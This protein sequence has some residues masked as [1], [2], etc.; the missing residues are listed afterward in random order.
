MNSGDKSDGPPQG[1]E[2]QDSVEI[3]GLPSP[4][5]SDCFLGWP[6]EPLKTILVPKHEG[7]TFQTLPLPPSQGL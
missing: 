5:S 7:T 1:E 2:S 6:F 4:F 3:H